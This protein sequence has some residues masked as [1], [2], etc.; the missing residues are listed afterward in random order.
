MAS[1]APQTLLFVTNE[2][3]VST[4]GGST[5]IAKG[6]IGLVDKGGVPTAAG[7]PVVTSVTSIAADRNRL[8]E[9][10]LGIAPLTPTRSQ[11]NKAYST[12]PFKL[13]EIVDVKV[14]YPKMGVSVDE[15][16]IG[17]DG[18]NASS[19]LVMSNGDN[20]VIDITLSGEA[21]GMLGYPEAKVTVKLYLE[22]PNTGSFT[23]HQIVEE[24]VKRLK[25][26][27]LVG[28]V[29]I[30]TYIDISPVNSTNISLAT[31]QLNDVPSTFY[32]LTV[33]DKGNHTALGL[34][35]AQYPTLVVKREA[36]TPGTSEAGVS[37]YVVIGTSL[38]AAYSLS[39]AALADANCDG[40]PELTTTTSTI[41]WVAGATCSA[42]QETFTLQLKDTDC[43]TN[44]L[45]AVQAAYPELEVLVDTENA[46]WA[47]TGTV[48]G[49]TTG[50]TLSLVINGVTYNTSGIFATDIATT[51]TNWVAGNA[52]AILAATGAVVTKGTG[53]TIV[54][55][56]LSEGFVVVAA[57]GAAFTLA[58]SELANI[59]TGTTGACQTVYRTV[60]TSDI[61]CEDCS[62]VLRDLFVVTA[63]APF[64]GVHWVAA[65]TTFSS[66]A[67]MGIHLK[68]KVNIFAGSEEFR[69]E[70]PFVYSSTRLSIANEAPGM[71]SESFN[72]GTNG[73]FKVKLMSIA[74]EP[75]AVGGQFYDMEERTRV[76]FENRQRL[77]G[78]NFGKLVLGQESHLKPT[79]QYVDY[80]VSVRTNRFAQSFSGEV[81]ENF[82]YHILV[83]AGKATAVHALAKALYEGANPSSTFPA[84]EAG[85]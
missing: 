1:H 65:P 11:S 60:V 85:Y 49:L 18:I 54:F 9:L 37:T 58:L 44:R 73:R 75:E 31:L 5:R 51:I 35:Q 81:V 74:T 14:N 52:A 13:S 16:I 24:G 7:M 77:A 57:S 21:I 55:T 23:M 29:P 4:S 43:G 33:K 61:V 79:S 10:R 34:V 12:V 67:L 56:D 84:L 72:M 2:G 78:N 82:D 15:F 47:Q 42:I 46:S 19:A 25:D 64:Q 59:G 28:G 32:R 70:M 17:Y 62:P 22:A 26:V 45:A 80:V 48:T 63:P 50:E 3:S 27:T 20:E 66:T 30:T 53:N 40:T 76:Y 68:G 41:A 36:Y 6:Q 69:D 83:E 71:V 38:P 8:Y 39:V